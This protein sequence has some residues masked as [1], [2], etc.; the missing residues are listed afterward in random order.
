MI[1]LWMVKSA[2]FTEIK[3]REFFAPNDDIEIKNYTFSVYFWKGNQPYTFIEGFMKRPAAL[4]L[5][6]NL[7]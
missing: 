2:N 6:E 5:R 4:G 1:P 7:N 3:L